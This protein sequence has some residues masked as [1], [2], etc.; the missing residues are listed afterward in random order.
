MEVDGE[1]VIL[2]QRALTVGYR[3]LGMRLIELVT[4]V[5]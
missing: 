1:A 3:A 5:G 2:S 4:V